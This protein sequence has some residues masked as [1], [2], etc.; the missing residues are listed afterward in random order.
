MFDDKFMSNIEDKKVLEPCVG[1]GSFVFSYLRVVYERAKL[2]RKQIGNLIKNIFFADNND[3]IL[4]NFFKCYKKFIYDVFLLD[5]DEKLLMSNSVNGLIFNGISQD[6]ISL[7]DA[8]K[9][10]I[11]FDIIITNPPYKNLKIDAKHYTDKIQYNID[12]DYYKTL[13]KTIFS[14]CDLSNKGV[15]NLYRIFFEKIILEYACEGC[16]ISL[17]IPNTFLADQASFSL[18][19]YCLYN[20]KINRLDLFE[21]KNRLFKGVTQ[22]VVNIYLQNRKDF[23]SS[24]VFHSEKSLSIINADF[25]IKNDKNLSLTSY[26]NDE[27]KKIKRLKEFPTIS[28]FPFIKN[29]RGELDM[30][31]DKKYLSAKLQCKNMIKGGNLQRFFLKNLEGNLSVKSSF[32]NKSNKAFYIYQKRIACP[33]ISNQKSNTR[34]K[35]SLIPDGY[36]LANSC[37]FLY[38]E[39]NKFGYDIY[40]LLGLLNT[41]L[42]NW[43]FKKFSSNNHIGN[44]EIAS[45]PLHNNINVI[46]KISKLTKSFLLTKEDRLLDEINNITNNGFGLLNELDNINLNDIINYSSFY[47]KII[48][49]DWTFYENKVFLAKKYKQFFIDNNYIL[50]N[51]GFKLSELDLEMITP[52]PQGGNWKDI[53]IEIVQK[54]QRLINIK[55]SGGRTTLYGRMK[56]DSPAYTIST[57]FNRP[58]NGTYVHPVINRVITAREAARLQSFPDNFYFYGNKSEVL[59]QIG[60]AVPCLFAEA[61]GRQLKYI[62]PS[63]KTFGDMFSG[64]GGM[65]HGLSRAGLRAIFAND[66]DL[67]SCITYQV[68]NPEVEVIHGDIK[69]KDIKSRIY[70]YSK[71]I[72]VLVGGPP[73][74]GFSHA[75]KRI[76]EDPR[77]M[78]FIEFIDAVK[79]LQPKIV[80]MENVSGFLSLNKG[81]FFR[82]VKDLLLDIGY[83]CDGKL[84][85]TIH[86]GVPQKRKRVIIIAVSKEF[87][88][89]VTIEQLFPI[90]LN[91]EVSIYEAIKSLEGIVPNTISKYIDNMNNKYLDILNY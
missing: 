20:S 18:R 46:K 17:L 48:C 1:M 43:F 29:L 6:Y 64:A 27:I 79:K 5:I 89:G 85:N 59:K 35:F 11:K 69:N 3:L 54:S 84:L 51:Q 82:Q 55:K 74:Q 67:A 7:Q 91:T 86:Y 73:C 47:K 38:V 23:N 32:L 44:Y 42:I 2:D 58:G 22:S 34:I 87:L 80:V 56:Y 78:L 31:I 65:S 71:K 66:I 9:K 16:F 24:I 52:I 13:K 33:Q 39:E 12:K 21:E 62:W 36:V 37:N 83:V 8:F 77:N 81:D 76:I 70:N 75:G 28:S 88:D 14:K 30:S 19:K 63:L 15:I 50:N 57:Y 41:E 61:I 49:N 53:P 4:N 68:N 90:K 25:I 26:S 40:Y 72:D 45:F 10:N 60:N